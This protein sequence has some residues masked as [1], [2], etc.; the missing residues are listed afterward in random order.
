MGCPAQVVLG[1]TLKFSIATHDP[2]TGV[3]TDAGSAPTYRVYEDE[4]ATPILTGSMAK[5]DDANTTGFYTEIITCSA[6]NGFEHYK[7]YTVYIEATVDSDKGGITYDFTCI[8]DPVNSQ[9][10]ALITHSY[11]ILDG[12]DNPI[13]DVLVECRTRDGTAKVQSAR[14]NAAGVATFY[15]VAGNYDFYSSKAGFDFSNP[16]QETVA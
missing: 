16:D 4:T 9:D 1:K 7:T 10:L 15:L 12:S 8:P 3:L 6:A 14:T 11:T 13:A 2:D 5:L